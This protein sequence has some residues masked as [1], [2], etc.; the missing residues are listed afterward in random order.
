MKINYHQKLKNKG[1][2]ISILVQ[3]YDMFKSNANNQKK[4]ITQVYSFA[5]LW[6]MPLTD[7]INNMPLDEDRFDLIILVKNNNFREIITSKVLLKPMDFY[8]KYLITFCCQSFVTF[9][10]S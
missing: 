10:L 1:K 5:P 9:K 2:D 3:W 8:E 7:V 6:I 4:Q